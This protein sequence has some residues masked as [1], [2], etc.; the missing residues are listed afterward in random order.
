V[1]EEIKYFIYCQL[2]RPLQSLKLM[3]IKNNK[4]KEEILKYGR[5]LEKYL[6]SLMKAKTKNCIY[7]KVVPIETS[8]YKHGL[9]MKKRK[10]E[11]IGSDQIDDCSHIQLSKAQINKVISKVKEI[12]NKIISMDVYVKYK[13]KSDSYE[14][15]KRI[16]PIAFPFKD[17]FDKN[18]FPWYMVYFND[19]TPKMAYNC[20]GSLCSDEYLF[21]KVVLGI[22][23]NKEGDGKESKCLK[24]GKDNKHVKSKTNK[25][26]LDLDGMKHE[27]NDLNSYCYCQRQYNSANTYMIACSNESLCIYN[28]WFH[29]SCVPEL[30]N[31]MKEEIENENFSFTCM[32]C[33]KKITDEGNFQKESINDISVK[34]DTRDRRERHERRSCIEVVKEVEN[35][36]EGG[37]MDLDFDVDLMNEED[38]VNFNMDGNVV[39]CSSEVIKINTE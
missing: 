15:N 18:I 36:E 35:E 9:L 6:Y 7:S 11:F 10:K 26:R 3:E 20:I 16:H 22:N 13:D 38:N 37:F 27:E 30:R 28:G 34:D 23:I 5:Y 12:Y 14:V 32:S 1:D 21:T 19:I 24:E 17:I 25:K 39:E 2:H 4:K 29:P 31:L 8:S 33:I